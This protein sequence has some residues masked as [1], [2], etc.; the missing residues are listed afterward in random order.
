MA[1]AA[2]LDSFDPGCRCGRRCRLGRPERWAFRPGYRTI[3]KKRPEEAIGLPETFV[4]DVYG[5]F[6]LAVH[7]PLHYGSWSGREPRLS[8]QDIVI[9]TKTA[10]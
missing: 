10:S 6:G 9:A 1:S 4:R 5:K 2:V 7:E 3:H 8:F